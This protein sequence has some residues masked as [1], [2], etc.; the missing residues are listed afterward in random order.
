MRLRKIVKVKGQHVEHIVIQMA[1]EADLNDGC[2]LFILPIVLEKWR[3]KFGRYLV[4]F[5]V[6]MVIVLAVA[7][8][9]NGFSP[10]RER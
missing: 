2:T 5:V 9:V 6:V 10:R 4:V 1:R 3:L 7:P 8:S